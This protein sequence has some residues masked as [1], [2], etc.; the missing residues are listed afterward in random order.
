QE[1][2]SMASVLAKPDHREESR[3]S[4]PDPDLSAYGLANLGRVH[5]NLSPALLTE[6]ALA[7]GEGLMASKGAFVAY[8]GARTGRS[9]QDRFIVSNPESRDEIGW[10]KVNRPIEPAVFDRMLDKV[11]AYLQGR[12]LFVKDVWACADPRHRLSVR[13][14]TEMTWHALFVHSLFLR[15]APG[16]R[17]DSTPGL[18]IIH[19]AG[20]R[21]EPQ[22]D[23]THSE[24]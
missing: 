1:G 10:G 5:V 16:E 11:G 17:S 21:T 14:I 8:T 15:P 9:P 24:V 4:A 18:T 19:A 2:N 22:T 3:G 13:V 12:D 6:M 23:G 20:L 7:R